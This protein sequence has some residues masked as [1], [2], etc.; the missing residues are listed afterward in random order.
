MKQGGE[1]MSKVLT[2]RPAHA[3][4]LPT[5]AVMNTFTRLAIAVCL[6]VAVGATALGLQSWVDGAA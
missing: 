6:L 3:S 2:P 4:L 5:A 1:G